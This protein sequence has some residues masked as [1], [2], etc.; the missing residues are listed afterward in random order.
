MRGRGRIMYLN[1]SVR[2]YLK[3]QHSMVVLIFATRLA[4]FKIDPRFAFSMS[5]G[6]MI[7][8]GYAWYLAVSSVFTPQLYLEN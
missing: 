3:I 7:L 2:I 8:F 4:F 5:T 1:Y 6:S